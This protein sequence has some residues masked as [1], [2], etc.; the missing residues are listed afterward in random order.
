MNED[1]LRQLLRDADAGPLSPADPTVLAAAVRG[2]LRRRRKSRNLATVL[3][4]L[5]C[6]AG[7]WSFWKRPVHGPIPEAPLPGQLAMSLQELDDLRS[8]TDARMEAVDE[9]MRRRA[10]VVVP[11]RPDPMLAVRLEL[12]RSA[13]IVLDTARGVERN[14][15][16]RQE[17]KSRYQRV[18]ELFP[19]SYGALLAKQRIRELSQG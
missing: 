7:S 1:R 18:I 19:D 4:V 3:S 11:E 13:I 17:A 16:D 10:I 14:A 15:G 12:E 9:L 2:R 6:L 8:D 5:L